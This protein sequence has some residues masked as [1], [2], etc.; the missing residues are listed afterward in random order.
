MRSIDTAPRSIIIV[1][2][3]SATTTS[4]RPPKRVMS[5][6]S[7]RIALFVPIHRA[8]ARAARAAQSASFAQRR[9]F[10]RALLFDELQLSCS[11]CAITSLDVDCALTA[12][13]IIRV[14]NRAMVM[15]CILP[16]LACGGLLQ[17]LAVDGGSLTV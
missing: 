8:F 1:G 10:S 5:A 13:T 9:A 11:L 14:R 16:P 2:D 6:W 17:K 12:P 7:P 4:E 15:R 3:S